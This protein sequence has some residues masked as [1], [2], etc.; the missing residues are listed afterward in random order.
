MFWQAR[1]T[2]VILI[3]LSTVRS[4]NQGYGLQI[5]GDTVGLFQIQ[6]N[7]RHDPYR[8]NYEE[9]GRQDCKEQTGK[10]Q[11][12]YCNR[13]GT[14]FCHLQTDDRKQ[15]SGNHY[16]FLPKNERFVGR[17]TVPTH[18]YSTTTYSTD[19]QQTESQECPMLYFL[20][21]D[22]GDL[23]VPSASSILALS[24]LMVWLRTMS[25]KSEKMT[26]VRHPQATA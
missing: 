9:Y 11:N 24:H 10:Q 4:C 21:K 14:A 1:F 22:K 2:Y 17:R 16:T 13:P 20:R 6:R 3:L 15:I 5:F 12:E 18:N 25:E 8:T 7:R 23:L 19:Q 26:G